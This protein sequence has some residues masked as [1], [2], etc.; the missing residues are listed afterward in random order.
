MV[1]HEK[2]DSIQSFKNN[3]IDTI[4]N[5]NNLYTQKL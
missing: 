3:N 2:N 5:D 1:H 4:K